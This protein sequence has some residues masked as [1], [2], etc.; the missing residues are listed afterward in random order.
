M[1]FEVAAHEYRVL[2]RFWV[3]MLEECDLLQGELIDAWETV[4]ASDFAAQTQAGRMRWFVARADGE[5]VASAAAILRDDGSSA[6]FKRPSATLAGIY[7]LPAYRRHGLARRLT[8]R[9]LEWCRRRGC[10]AVRLQASQM[11]RPLYASLGFVPG[12]E[13]ILNLHSGDGANAYAE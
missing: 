12:T 10:T 8:Q 1:T 3:A 9:A 13:M 11:G 2:A 5:I 6:I 7:V 4:L